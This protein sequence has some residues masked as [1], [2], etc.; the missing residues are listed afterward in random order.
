MP[1]FF[2]SIHYISILKNSQQD[3]STTALSTRQLNNTKTLTNR[4]NY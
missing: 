4:D 1:S 3:T 2:Q